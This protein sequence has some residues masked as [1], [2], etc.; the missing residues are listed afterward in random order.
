[1]PKTTEEE[2]NSGNW[3]TSNLNSF[4]GRNGALIQHFI[5]FVVVLIVIVAFFIMSR[6]SV[7]LKLLK[8]IR[9]LTRNISMTLV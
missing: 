8:K 1:L 2:D 3:L 6:L 7:F 4:L 5:V 9:L